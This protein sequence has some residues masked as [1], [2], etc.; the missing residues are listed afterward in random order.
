MKPQCVIS[1]TVLGYDFL[2]PTKLQRLLEMVCPN[3]SDRSPELFRE[4][5]DNLNFTPLFSK[6]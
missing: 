2:K 3:F 6:K 1:A 4:K 5:L